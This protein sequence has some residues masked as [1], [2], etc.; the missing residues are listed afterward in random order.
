[1]TDEIE[2]AQAATDTA[3]RR[4]I[5]AGAYR[6][7]LEKGFDAASMNDITRAAGV[8]KGTIYAYFHGKDDLFEAVVEAER[9]RVTGDLIGLLET[10]RPVRDVLLEFGEGVAAL[11]CREDV[12]R[13]QRI[14]IAVA[15]RMPDLGRRFH[16]EG[17]ARI[18]AALRDYLSEVAERGE[19]AIDDAGM[20]AAQ[21]IDMCSG[22]LM[23]E[24]LYGVKTGG[25][26][27]ATAKA[28]ADSAVRVFLAA[29][30]PSE[31]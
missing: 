1:M 21:F 7:F 5:L 4:Q 15:E 25:R 9:S 24:R 8:S 29:Y 2:T 13:A 30:A 6:V 27:G 18:H 17:P 31:G 23:R 28:L 10:A 20:A 11:A 19:L 12:I 16:A 14:V 26:D 3:K 22:S